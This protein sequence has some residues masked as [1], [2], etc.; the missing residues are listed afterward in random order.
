MPSRCENY[1]ST[2][3]YFRKSQYQSHQTNS[4]TSI[5]SQS[6]KPFDDIILAYGSNENEQRGPPLSNFGFDPGDSPPATLRGFPIQVTSGCNPHC[7][8]TIRSWKSL[9]PIDEVLHLLVSPLLNFTKLYHCQVF[10]VMSFVLLF[11]CS[12]RF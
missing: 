9:G 8:A 1:I 2:S 6:N 11:Q 10:S 4:N 3:S 7:S 5:D 12:L